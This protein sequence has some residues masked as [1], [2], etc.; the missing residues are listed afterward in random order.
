M[1][2]F[3]ILQVENC[4]LINDDEV[5]FINLSFFSLKYWFSG[6]YSDSGEMVSHFDEKSGIVPCETDWGRWWQNVD[7][8]HVEITSFTGLKAKDIAICITPSSIKC[9]YRGQIIL[10]VRCII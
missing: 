4:K 10:E 2:T 6:N 1:S 7:E 5:I 9:T 8:V 3:P